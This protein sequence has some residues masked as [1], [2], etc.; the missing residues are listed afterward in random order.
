MISGMKGIRHARTED[1]AGRTLVGMRSISLLL[2]LVLVVSGCARFD[3]RLD[4]PFTPAP[5]PG[6][7]APPP[8]PPLAKVVGSS[9]GAWQ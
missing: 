9:L 7:G 3:D 5:G 2:A 4:D 6:Q 1:S 8:S